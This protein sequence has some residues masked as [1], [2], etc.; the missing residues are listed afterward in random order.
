MTVF[1]GEL[2]PNVGMSLESGPNV[3]VILLMYWSVKQTCFDDGSTIVSLR[4]ESRIN[5]STHGE[6][7]TTTIGTQHRHG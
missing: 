2:V 7:A 5:L 1:S 3:K 6:Q 4:K